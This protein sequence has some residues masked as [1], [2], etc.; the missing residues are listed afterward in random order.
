MCFVKIK[1]FD[2]KIVFEALGTFWGALLSLSELH[3][4]SQEAP[5]ERGRRGESIPCISSALWPLLGPEPPLT[6]TGAIMP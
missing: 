4:G 1:V 5:L 2:L 6:L 3:F